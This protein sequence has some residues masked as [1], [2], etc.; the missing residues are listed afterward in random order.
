MKATRIRRIYYILLTAALAVAGLCLIAGALH[1]YYTGGEQI[2][3]LSKINNTFRHIAIPV[4]IALALVIGSFVLELFLPTPKKG[5]PEKNHAM[6][7]HKL[8]QRANLEACGDKE[9]CK[10]VLSL[11]RQRKILGILSI[12]MLAAASVF[13]LVFAL[14]SAEYPSLTTGHAVTET[15]VRNTLVWA[16][17]LLVP[18]ILSLYTTYAT[19]SGMKTEI[20]LLRHVAL[21]K[22]PPKEAVKRCALQLNILRGSLIALSVVLIVVGAI[23]DGWRDVLT[24]A[25]AI[26]TECVGLG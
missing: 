17:C 24:K 6:I 2:Y 26:C 20:E 11:R 7:L 19:R 1:V 14:N 22:L 13:F 16:A 15:M 23:G 5:K 25:V 12:A 10:M 21:R 8:Q 9:L 3:T 18:F 4:Y